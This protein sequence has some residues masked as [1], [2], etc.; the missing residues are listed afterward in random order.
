MRDTRVRLWAAALLLALLA[1]GCRS[2]RQ[3][4]APT[5]P[6]PEAPPV[7][8]DTVPALP[9]RQYT[10]LQFTGV[11]EGMTVDGQLRI[12]E[13]SAMWLSVN[14]I[15]EVGRALATAD[16]VF[17]RAPLLGRDEGMDYATLNRATGVKTS[18]AELQ[19]IALDENAS[20]RINALARRLGFNA[21]VRITAR[22]RVDRLSFPFQ[23]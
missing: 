3:T 16:S 14:K 5:P 12:A 21:T 9:Q 22:R 6:A 1:A 20:E 7:A 2:S 17:L 13:D 15:I 8:A 10:V 4:V 23:R 18:L 19:E 11:V